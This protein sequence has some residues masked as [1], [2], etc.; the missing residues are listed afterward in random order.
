MLNDREQFLKD[1][2]E[3][4]AFNSVEADRSAADAP[5]G[6]EVRGALD[7]FLNKAS[8]YGL[9]VGE[10]H[11][12]Y[13]YAEYGDP[14]K[15]LIGILAH[16]D[17]VPAGTGWTSD[18][19]IVR[20]NG[21]VIY[22]RGVADDKGPLVAMLYGLKKLRDEKAVLRHRVRL[23]VGCNE[24]TGSLCLKKYAE[25]GEI[26]VVSLVPD[27]DFPIINSEKGILH[28]DVIVAPDEAF[29]SAVASLR[30]GTRANVVPGEASV[31]LKAG[32]EACE[33]M[34]ALIANFAPGD[35][36]STPE[37]AE[38]LVRIGAKPA[39]FTVTTAANGETTVTA[40]GVAGHAMAPDKS[41]NAL[42]KIWAVL[43]AIIPASETAK[44]VFD[45]LCRH[46]ASKVIGAYRED[47]ETGALTMNMGVAEYDGGDLTLKFDFRLPISAKPDETEA[48]LSKVFANSGVIKRARFADNLYMPEDSPLIKTLL[49]VY[50]EVTGKKDPRPIQ[51]GGGTYAR[52]LPN[53]VAYGPTE[54]NEVTDLHN[55]DEHIELASL[56]RLFDVYVKAIEKLDALY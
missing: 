1:L 53:A 5:F 32:S 48:A 50:S 28:T 9:K 27:S 10:N 41:D 46:D 13:G 36:F 14:E 47:K 16:A 34:R 11:G 45:D 38:N 12:Y 26:P 25:E 22:G 3:I 19:F 17:I 35:V 43:E 4:V 39:D 37:I 24:E 49:G 15:P 42:W 31:T 21:D 56:D 51:T 29:T 20:R 23:I 30:A 2:S 6:T 33:K 54:E 18:P 40:K 7:W 55:A 44:R 8:Y 52:E